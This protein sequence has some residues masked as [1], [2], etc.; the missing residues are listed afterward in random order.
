MQR[1]E[2]LVQQLNWSVGIQAHADGPAVGTAV[3]PSTTAQKQSPA[4]PASSGQSSTT[5]TQ[6]GAVG[7]GAPGAA[8]KSGSEGRQD[9]A[10]AALTRFP[11][12]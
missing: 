3:V 11:L 7:V 2:H 6:Q 8:A 5:G 4:N 12:C 1:R 10:R 9:D